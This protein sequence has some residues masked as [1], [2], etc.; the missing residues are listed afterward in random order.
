MASLL[1]SE[2]GPATHPTTPC[3]HSDL[4]SH[5][6]SINLSFRSLKPAT[7]SMNPPLS[8]KQNLVLSLNGPVDSTAYASVLES[9]KCPGLG[10]QVHAHALKTG[11]CGHE[12]L[13]TKLLQMYGR[14]GS[15]EEARLLFEN[16]PLR[17]IYSWA[18]ILTVLADNGHFEESLSLFQE[19]QY[20]DICLEFFIFPVVLKVCSGLRALE[21]GRQLHGYVIKSEFASNIYVGNSLIDAYGKCG[22][23]DDAMVVLAKMPK[24]D[25]VSWNSVITACAANGLVFEAFEFLENMRLQD[26][27]MPN[28]VSWSAMIGGFAQ[29]G[30]DEEALE[31]LCRMQSAGFNPNARTLASV[32][33]ACARLQN[34]GLGKEIHGYITR[35]GFMSNPFVANGLV[36]VYRRC[37]DMGSA[38]KIFSK[39]SERNLVSFNTMIVGYCENGEVIEAR[40][41]FDQMELVGIKKDIIAWN[42]MIAGYVDNKLFDESLKM[43]RNLQMEEGIVP[44]SFTLGSVLS[45]CADLNCLKLGKEIHAYSIIRG[46]QSDTFVGGALVEMYCRCQDLVAARMAFDEVIEKDTATWNALISG[47]SR[48]NQVEDVQE[49]LRK[50]KNDSLEPNTYTWNGIIAGYLDNGH[51][52]AALQLFSQLQTSNPKADIYTVGMILHACSRLASIDRGK[53]V[54]V[55]SIRRGYDM[56]VHIGAALVDMYAKCGSIK[57]AWLAFNRISKLN[58]VSWNSML[59][60]YAMHGHGGEGID[61]F[62]KMLEDGIT[63]DEVTFLSVLSLCVHAGSVDLGKEYFGLMCHYNIEPTIKHYTCMVD[64]LSRAGCLEEAYD[65]VKKMPM[66]PDSV[67]WGALL[68]GCVLHRSIELGEIAADKLIELDPYN[69]ANYVLLANMYAYA[70]RWDDLART[71]QMIKDKGMHKSPGCSWFEDRD[72]IHV[73]LACDKSHNKTEEIYATLDSLTTQMKT[74]GY[75][76]LI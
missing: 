64:L 66:E 32:L 11:F 45:A 62:L 51:N 25:C 49:L 46:L 58:L 9:C 41:I 39:F 75:T 13:E 6:K 21:L 74:E 23:L 59:S 29:N 18:G 70:G 24:R 4:S 73:F 20:E 12:F 63:P 28:V 2:V 7:L 47:Y 5:H 44:D 35:H 57:H 69:T 50:M 42:S 1:I 67:T 55:H 30:Y 36:D 17:N 52:E 40:D 71:R 3:H 22:R 54:H 38:L 27:L 48:C 53:Q 10:K 76:A 19:L 37:A 65:L 16:M 33:P 15:I 26:D 60:G 14:C 31:L 61:L 68:G 8:D 43:F 34:L 56:D 72:L